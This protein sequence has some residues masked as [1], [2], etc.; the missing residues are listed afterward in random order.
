MAFLGSEG[1]QLFDC[2]HVSAYA[3]V[4]N[5]MLMF[6]LSRATIDIEKMLEPKVDRLVIAT[7]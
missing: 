3:L 1:L 5:G 4:F 6:L 2:W 7:L